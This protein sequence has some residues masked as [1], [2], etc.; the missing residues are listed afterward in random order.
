MP[1]DPIEPNEMYDVFQTARRLGLKPSTIR[2]MIHERTIDVYRPSVR[3]V[4]ISGRTI[5]ARL[6]KGFTPAVKIERA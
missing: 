1:I 5:Q 4:R 2:R 3:A 6:A